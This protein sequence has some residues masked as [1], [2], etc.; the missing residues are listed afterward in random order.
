[1][2]RETLALLCDPVHGEPLEFVA[3]PRPALRSIAGGSEYPMVHGI[4]IFAAQAAVVGANAHYQKLY[5]RIALVYDLANSFS[6]C[7]RSGGEKQYRADILRELEVRDGDRVIEISCGTGRNLLFLN[8]SY[9]R[10]E[11]YGLD[12]SLGMLR[13][14]QRACRREGAEIRLFQG[15]AEALP[16]RDHTFDV[17]FHVGGINFFTDPARAMQE[18]IRIAKPGTKVVVVDETERKVRSTYERVPFVRRWFQDR[19]EPV[20]IP[21][22][23]VPKMVE[24]VRVQELDGGNMYCLTFR[25]PRGADDQ[26]SM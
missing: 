15:L 4:P 3:H 24:D 18:M 19:R 26:A 2:R 20:E 8:R 16:F 10:L 14:C 23:A 7:L 6:F 25:K 9:S 22:H 17:V 5:D 11:L 21:I 12:L 1:M 13:V